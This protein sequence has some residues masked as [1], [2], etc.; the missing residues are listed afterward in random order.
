MCNNAVFP[1]RC[2][3]TC[4]VEMRLADAVACSVTSFQTAA[5]VLAT[6]DFNLWYFPHYFIIYFS[7]ANSVNTKEGANI[8]RETQYSSA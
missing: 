8:S 4:E 7:V 5:Q 3:V 2:Y 1:T 6:P